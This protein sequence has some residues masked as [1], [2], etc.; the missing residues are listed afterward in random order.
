[1]RLF[2]R[3]EELT[4]KM[5]SLN[6]VIRNA[7]KLWKGPLK[8]K[9]IPIKR[10]FSEEEPVVLGDAICLEQL[11][12]NLISN[13]L[14]AIESADSDSPDLI[15]VTTIVEKGWAVV[16]V[17]DSGPGIEKSKL[18]QLNNRF[19]FFKYKRKF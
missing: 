5:V 2:S 3:Q 17:S 13:A 14:D 19:I 8:L 4:L 6:D 10:T 12:L 7:F 15:E 18:K 11:V 9:N 1:M 16:E